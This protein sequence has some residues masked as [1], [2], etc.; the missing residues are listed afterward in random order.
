MIK[1]L[2]SITIALSIIGAFA[3]LVKIL[4]SIPSPERTAI[5]SSEAERFCVD[6]FLDSDILKTGHVKFERVGST[7]L[8]DNKFAAIAYYTLNGV[9]RGFSCELIYLKDGK[10][11]IQLSP[12]NAL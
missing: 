1:K 9:P 7:K 3:L 4:I 12:T 8:G 5:S 2:K 10:M 11:W 6:K